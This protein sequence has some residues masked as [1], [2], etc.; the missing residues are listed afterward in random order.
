LVI[1]FFFQYEEQKI[2]KPIDSRYIKIILNEWTLQSVREDRFLIE[3]KL[4]CSIF[5]CE[6]KMDLK[7]WRERSPSKLPVYCG[8]LRM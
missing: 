5:G 7:E 4:Q 1:L 8:N 2:Q 3:K 6:R